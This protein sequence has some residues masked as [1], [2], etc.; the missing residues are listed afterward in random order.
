MNLHAASWKE[1]F[2][3]AVFWLLVI[4]SGVSVGIGFWQGSVMLAVFGCVALAVLL[5]G[6]LIEPCW[7]RVTKYRLGEGNGGK[8]SDQKPFRLLFLS[9]L[10]AGLHKQAKFYERIAQRVTALG[11]D[12]VV[13]GGDLVNERSKDVEDLQAI[14]QLKPPLGTWFVLGN[15]DF[16][17]D[18]KALVKRVLQ[19]G[20]R[21]LTNQSLTFKLGAQTLL[22]IV[23]LDDSWY[24][25]PDMSLVEAPKKGM[26]ILITHE[27]DLLLDLPEGCADVI[28]LGHTH[29]GQIRLPGYGP[30]ILPQSV[31]RSYD[32]GERIWKNMRVIISRGI[33]ETLVRARLGA[34]PE[35]VVL[36]T[37]TQIR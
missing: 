28:L 11:P 13:L 3:E 19:Q 36:D 6:G 12:I 14:F 35:I 21:D 34:R 15:H 8:T 18:P 30:L 29:G 17:D 22:E 32:A 16:F 27:P 25:T 9:D 23:G 10:H 31:S 7:V 37:Y 20:V 2:F 5:Y 1:P 33:A 4:V 24:G 26:R